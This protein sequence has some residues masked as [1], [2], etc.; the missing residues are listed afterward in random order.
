MGH[1]TPSTTLRYTHLDM[2]F[3]HQAVAKLPSLRDTESPQISP[4]REIGA[5]AVAAK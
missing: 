3:K 5:K 2:G 4:S 1:K